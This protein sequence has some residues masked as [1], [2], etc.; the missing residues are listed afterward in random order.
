MSNGVAQLYMYGV[1]LQEGSMP[2]SIYGASF[3]N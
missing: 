2:L 3:I 1:K